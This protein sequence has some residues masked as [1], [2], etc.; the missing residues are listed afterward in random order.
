VLRTAQHDPQVAHAFLKVARLLR[1]GSTLLRPNVVMRVFWASA[2]RM[3]AGFKVKQAAAKV[4][5]RGA[6]P[7][8]STRPD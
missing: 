5:R 7:Q 8:M 1:P 4:L 2:R 3:R 6:A